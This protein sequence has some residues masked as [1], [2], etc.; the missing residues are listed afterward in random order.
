MITDEGAVNVLYGGSTGLTAT[1]DQYWHQDSPGIIDPA[2]FRDVFGVTL[3]AGDFN[4]NGRDDLAVGSEE[5]VTGEE[6]GDG[7]VNVIY[8]SSGAG[9]TAT[10]DQFWH[11]N[12]GG[13]ID[14]AEPFDRFGGGLVGQPYN[15][16]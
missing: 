2:E 6:T 4:N 13:V 7:A 16:A 5:G 10:G 11:Q 1:D 14:P 12:S 8:G 15:D 9:L 3:S